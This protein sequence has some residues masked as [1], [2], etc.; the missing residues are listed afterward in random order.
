MDGDE[1]MSNGSEECHSENV[2]ESNCLHSGAEYDVEDAV[3]TSE[4]SIEKQLCWIRRGSD[5]EVSR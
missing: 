2:S 5:G 3:E 1:E 4:R